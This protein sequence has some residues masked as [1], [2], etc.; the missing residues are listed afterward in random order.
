MQASFAFAAS[1]VAEWRALLGPVILPRRRRAPIGQLVKSIISART[2]DAV[3]T[4]AYDRLVARYG[5]PAR[6]ARAKPAAVARAIGDVTFAESKAALLLA[7]LQQIERQDGGFALAHLTVRP[8]AD[9]LAWLEQLPGVGRKVSASTLNASTLARPVMIVD[10]HVL[11]VLQRLGFVPPAADY[12]AASEAVTAAMPAWPGDDFLGFHIALKR[13]GQ[14]RCRWDAPD[15][16]ACPLSA[17]GACPGA[18]AH[19]RADRGVAGWRGANSTRSH[20]LP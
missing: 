2:R 5:T 10:T 1:D 17:N 16:A 11:R 7:A 19:Q 14:A 12:R 4:A 18:T 15:C 20:R 8:L 13:L 3:S 6:L 9:A